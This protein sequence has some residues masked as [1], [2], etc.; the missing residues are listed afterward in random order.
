[1]TTEPDPALKRSRRPRTDAPP[2]RPMTA[3]R[4]VVGLGLVSLSADMVYEGARSITGPL[5][6]QLGA[7]AM[8]AGVVVGAGEAAAL[9]LRLVF[10]RA[11][12]RASRYWPMTI[13]GYALTAISVPLLAITPFVG[14]AGLALACA[15]ILAERTGKAVRSPAKSTLLA[16]VATD[17]GLGRAFGVH[18]ALDQTGAFAGPLLVAGIMATTGVIWPS[19]AILLVPGLA[20]M[21]LLVWLQPRI[22]EPADRPVDQ[23][24]AA[25]GAAA[26]G[27]ATAGLGAVPAPKTPLPRTFWL[28]A[29]SS[30]AATAGLAPFGVISFHLSREHVI[31]LAHIPLV[32]AAGMAIAAVAALGSG[33][34]YDRW[35]A[36]VLYTLPPI[37]AAVPWLAFTDRAGL[38]LVGVLV[39]GAASGIQD[40]TVKALVAD[41]VPAGRRAT[42]YGVFAAVQGAGAMGGGVLAGSIYP[43]STALLGGA[44]AAIE[45]AALALFAITMRASRKQA[46]AT[47]DTVG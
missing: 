40:S 36:A 16:F 46:V 42:A 47:V 1:M 28:F 23:S 32:Y 45:A 11:A 7:S 26:G 38:A 21:L 30:A 33:I 37:A 13:A 29:A 17:V 20:A 41:L 5:L 8:L 22:G 25:S 27:T 44:I 18:K 9:M 43:Y 34:G 6:E 2:A 35:R 39:W 4:A 14:A 12:D 24:A 15:L 19:M 31:A 10:G 3:W